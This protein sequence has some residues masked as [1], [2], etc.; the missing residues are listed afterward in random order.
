MVISGFIQSGNSA[1][2][3]PAGDTIENVAKQPR[4]LNQDQNNND[5]NARHRKIKNIDAAPVLRDEDENQNNRIESKIETVVLR[6]EDLIADHGDHVLENIPSGDKGHGHTNANENEEDKNLVNVSHSENMVLTT[7]IQS[8][9]DNDQSNSACAQDNVTDTDT[10]DNN[11]ACG[12]EEAE[13]IKLKK[14]L[15]KN[16]DVDD[17]DDRCEQRYQAKSV[18]Q[19]KNL[20]NEKIA[21][22][23]RVRSQLFKM[24]F[25]VL[26]IPIWNYDKFK[27]DYL[28]E[29]FFGT[30]YKVR[31]SLLESLLTLLWTCRNVGF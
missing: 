30:T 21:F 10:G 9:E 24:D 12:N 31:R 17:N 27:I 1:N 18:S 4:T 29:G 20:M 14:S 3:K 2:T 23:I 22:S 25:S 11:N 19:R 6:K 15:K 13:P 16:L 8:Q 7:D 5:E 28:S 26:N